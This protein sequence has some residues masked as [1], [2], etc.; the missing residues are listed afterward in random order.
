MHLEEFTLAEALKDGG[1]QT[2]FIGKWHLS[3]SD[4]IRLPTEQGFDVNVAGG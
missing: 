2:G 4:S 1:Y 3:A